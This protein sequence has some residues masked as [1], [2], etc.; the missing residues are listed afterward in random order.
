MEATRLLLVDDDVEWAQT[1]K[2]AIERLGLLVTHATD[3]AAMDRFLESEKIDL[4]VLDL[5][6]PGED[7]LSVCRRLAAAANPI[8]I[9]VAT[10]LCDEVDRVVGLEVGA[11][12]YLGKPFSARELVARVRAVLRRSR[13]MVQ[14][15]ATLEAVP[16]I[17]FQGFALDLAA[18]RLSGPSGPIELTTSEFELLAI[19]ARRPNQPLTR[20]ALLSLLPSESRASGRS[21][22]VL[23]VRL[24]KLLEPDLR[25][26]RLIK[27][28]WSIGYV[29]TP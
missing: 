12:D 9:I 3:G 10:A 8:P 17:S 22:D 2:L 28:V 13:R 11:D 6:L 27:T 18:R 16:V 21:I 1:M 5:G 26:P 15:P 24:R 4:V 23:I 19:F 14:A 7:G 20:D 25:N 29:F